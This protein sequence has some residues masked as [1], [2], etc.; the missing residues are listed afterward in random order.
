MRPATALR[1][2]FALTLTFSFT[3]PARAD[4]PTLRLAT[5]AP[6]S[7]GWAREFGA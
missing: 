1:L 6:E 7:S 4:T 3:T 2:A 5:I